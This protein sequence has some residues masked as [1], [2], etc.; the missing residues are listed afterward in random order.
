MIKIDKEPIEADVLIIGGG[1]GGLASA[2]GLAQKGVASIVLEKASQLGEIGAG[3][4]LGPNAFHAFDTLGVGDDARKMAVSAVKDLAVPLAAAIGTTIAAFLPKI[5]GMGVRLYDAESGDCWGPCGLGYFIAARVLWDIEEADR[6]DEWID[7]VIEADEMKL[8][9]FERHAAAEGDAE[10]LKAMG[11][12]AYMIRVGDDRI[13][14]A[15][16][17]E[18]AVLNT[19]YDLLERL[20][21]RWLIPRLPCRPARC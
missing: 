1:I 15:G 11:P 13:V 9:L 7:E 6:V 12:E 20:G 10:R 21:C 5:H 2:I 3:I 8:H 19:C 4:Q 17:S 16:N 14:L 18:K